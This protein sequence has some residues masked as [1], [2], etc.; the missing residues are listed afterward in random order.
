MPYIKPEDRERYREG[1]AQVVDALLSI[2]EEERDGHVNYVVTVIMKRVYQPSKYACYNK[3]MGVLTCIL[4]EFYR[5]MV[6]P[7]EDIKIKENSDV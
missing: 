4:F 7:Y 3:A 6:G 2:P 5:R 1:I